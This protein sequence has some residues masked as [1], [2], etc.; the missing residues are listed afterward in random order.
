MTLSRQV[1]EVEP[2][3]S[4]DTFSEGIR[5]AAQKAHRAK[6]PRTQANADSMRPR[7]TDQF[8][9]PRGYNDHADHHHG[10]ASHVHARVR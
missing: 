3:M 4:I 8:D 5:A 10:P 2:G 6:Y 1:P 9:P 7:E